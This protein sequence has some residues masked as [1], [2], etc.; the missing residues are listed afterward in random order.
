M[1]MLST[2][3]NT[4][5]LDFFLSFLVDLFV[6]TGAYECPSFWSRDIFHSNKVWHA[7]EEFDS[8][9]QYSQGNLANGTH[10]VVWLEA[11]VI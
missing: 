3:H 8:F 10:P 7:A 6:L 4:H 5:S 1:H 2:M 9:D 11:S